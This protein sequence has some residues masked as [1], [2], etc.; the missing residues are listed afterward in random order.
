MLKWEIILI[1]K[2][3]FRML[4]KKFPPHKKINKNPHLIL[5]E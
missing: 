1:N 4:Y 3:I 5:K 2:V